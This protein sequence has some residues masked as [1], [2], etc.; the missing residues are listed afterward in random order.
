MQPKAAA[1]GACRSLQPTGNGLPPAAAFDAALLL[2]SFFTAK[3]PLE[4]KCR[5][6]LDFISDHILQK[7]VH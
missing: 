1:T 4:P 6:T 5:R 2:E 3:D 7:E